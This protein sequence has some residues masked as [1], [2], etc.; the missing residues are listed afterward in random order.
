VL[1]RAKLTAGSTVI[2]VRLSTGFSGAS[3]FSALER[4]TISG[5]EWVLY[6]LG[7]ALIPESGRLISG[8]SYVSLQALRIEAERISGT[9]SLD[10]DCLILIPYDE[11]FV[12]ANGGQVVYAG[13]DERPVYVNRSADGATTAIGFTGGTP[14]FNDIECNVIGGMPVGVTY[15]VLAASRAGSAVLADTLSVTC[16]AYHRHSTLRGAA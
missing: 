1:L 16:K 5:T 6:E 13:G 11:G 8:T 14:N 12:Y 3:T 9:A 10:L 15:G 7:L 4:V 2:N